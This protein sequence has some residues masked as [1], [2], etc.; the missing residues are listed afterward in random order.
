[1][2]I[3]KKGLCGRVVSVVLAGLLLVLFPAPDPVPAAKDADMP[4][5]Q[6]EMK[7]HGKNRTATSR[8]RATGKIR[9]SERITADQA[10]SFPADI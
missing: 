5:V 8:R 10:V 4:K 2:K 7:K 3:N 1:M 6:A 9:P